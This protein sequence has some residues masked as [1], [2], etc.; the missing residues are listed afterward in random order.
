MITL[1]LDIGCTKVAAAHITPDGTLLA[2]AERPIGPDPT[3]TLTSLVA[4]FT[5]PGLAAV[6]IS[7][8]GPLNVLA[9]TVD[10]PAWR[11][12]PLA[13]AVFRATD[14]PVFLAGNAQCLT[15]GEWWL[16]GHDTSSLLGIVVSTSI[17]GGLVLNGSPLLGTTG[18]AGHIGHVIIDPDGAPCPCGARGC[19]NTIASTPNMLGWATSQGWTGK[20]PADLTTSA[21]TGN[22]IALK[23]ITRAADALA[24]AIH[25]TATV[26]DI[27]DVV[28]A[29]MADDL[30]PPLR[31]ALRARAGMPFLRDINV[32]RTTL[33][34]DAALLGA[35]A[36]A[37]QTEGT[38]LGTAG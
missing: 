27:H 19:L 4:D 10:I 14:R 5:V 22:E 25:N 21:R 33:P 11:D 1:A 37:L 36:L 9:G 35:A 3:A 20:T 17:S 15:A 2:R 34:R 6:G 26:L 31:R 12:F 8:A 30:L 32:T 7:A 16:G 28:L 24:T 18:N 23:A 38:P 29:G 13:D